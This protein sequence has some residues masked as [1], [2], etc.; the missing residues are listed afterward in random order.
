MAAATANPGRPKARFTSFQ[1]QWLWLWPLPLEGD[2]QL[3]AKWDAIGL[4]ESS[5]VIS[6]EQLGQALGKVRKYWSD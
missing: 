2:T 6:A 3:I 5:V 1:P 4:P